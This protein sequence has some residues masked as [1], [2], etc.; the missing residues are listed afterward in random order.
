MQQSQN[1]NI[2]FRLTALWA[3]CESGLGGWMHAIGLPFTGFFVGGFAIVIISLIANFSENNS[4]QILQSTLLVI[5]LKA[6]ISPQ[7]PPPAYIAV[8]FQGLFGTLCFRF[9]PKKTATYLFAIIALLESAWQKILVATIIFGKN[10]WVS[11]DNFFESLLRDFK[12]QSNYSFS[13]WLILSYSLVY[14]IWAI[15]IAK[16]CLKIPKL[17]AEKADTMKLEF[18]HEMFENQTEII[19]KKKHKNKF[20]NTL[21]ILFLMIAL[22][23]WSENNFNKASYIIIRTFTVMAI[24]LWIVRPTF[25]WLLKNWLQKSKT[26]KKEKIASIEN[27]LPELR[28]YLYPAY[29]C[30]KRHK[31]GLKRYQLFLTYLLV[32]T[33]YPY[34][35]ES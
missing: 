34:Q 10:L 26:T 1:K 7:S 30:S 28:Q 11:L 27:Y 24:L 31:N 4:K 3:L 14:L 22:F 13:F 33:I 15:F 9:L 5:A 16:Y 2:V 23:Y 20:I 25:Q 8:A 21:I 18:K 12:I 6:A 29:R 35:N 32:A 19:E 17:L